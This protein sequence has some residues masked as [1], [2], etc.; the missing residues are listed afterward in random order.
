MI[1]KQHRGYN[2]SYRLVEPNEGERTS[3]CCNKCSRCSPSLDL[4]REL[5]QEEKDLIEQYAKIIAE[6]FLWPYTHVDPGE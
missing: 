2:A 6:A 1:K 5:S 4:S 3:L